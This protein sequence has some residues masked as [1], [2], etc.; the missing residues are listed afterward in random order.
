MNKLILPEIWDADLYLRLS[1]DDRER[2]ESN[3]I[4]NQ[5]DLALDWVS[6]NPDI[7]V[8]HILSDDGFTGANFDRNAF[9]EMIQ[10]IESGAVNCV[11]VKDVRP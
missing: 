9:R 3:S 6:R 1:K 2:D 5:R 10:H 4:K 7:R 11:I 8:A